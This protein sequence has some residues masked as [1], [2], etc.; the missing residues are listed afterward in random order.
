[1]RFTSLLLA[2]LMGCTAE[3]PPPAVWTYPAL[4]THVAVAGFFPEGSGPADCCLDL[5]GDGTND[6]FVGS[7]ANSLRGVLGGP[8]ANA[9]L[10]AVF[11]REPA[12]TLVFRGL[13]ASTSVQIAWAPGELVSPGHAV[14]DPA[15]IHAETRAPVAPFA[16]VQLEGDHLVASG[17]QLVLPLPDFVGCGTG[18]GGGTL[19]VGALFGR[20]VLEDVR[21]EAT[22]SVEPSGVRLTDGLLAGLVSIEEWTNAANRRVAERCPTAVA[23]FF[24]VVGAGRGSLAAT[25]TDPGGSACPSMCPFDPDELFCAEVTCGCM[26]IESL[27]TSDIDGDHDG[28]FESMSVGIFFDSDPVSVEPGAP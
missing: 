13:D 21:L 20:L 27:T 10:Q 6:N 7:V 25:C 5:D 9:T 22:L 23:P 24:E 1:M 3:E 14:L 19:Y 4:G 15:W 2:L 12:W 8:T 11:D 18:F 16:D 28:V 26:L 17:G